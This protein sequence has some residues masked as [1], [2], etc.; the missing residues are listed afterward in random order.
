M[1]RFIVVIALIIVALYVFKR[2]A[3]AQGDNR[4]SN[5][6]RNI[7]LLLILAAIV[8]VMATSGKFLLPKIFQV[9]KLIMPIITKFL[10]L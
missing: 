2:K 7:I 4:K 5:F 10:P 3:I 6:L 9:I 1:I 8:L